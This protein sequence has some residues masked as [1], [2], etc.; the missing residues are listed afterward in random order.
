VP[1]AHPDEIAGL[2]A[3]VASDEARFMVGS[4]VSMDGGLTA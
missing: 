1:H 3:Y 4:V 2:V